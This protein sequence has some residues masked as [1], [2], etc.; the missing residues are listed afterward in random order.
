MSKEKHLWRRVKTY[1]TH[2]VAHVERIDAARIPDIHLM[3]N[4]LLTIWLELKTVRQADWPKKPGTTTNFGLDKDQG[5]WHFT[6]NRNKGTS[7]IL[8]FIQH[9]D[10]YWVFSGRQGIVLAEKYPT[11][12]LQQ[13]SKQFKTLDEALGSIL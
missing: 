11:G 2:K 1:L 8:V 9:L 6:Y 13:I 10:E 3:R 7:Y 4:D 12:F 5:T